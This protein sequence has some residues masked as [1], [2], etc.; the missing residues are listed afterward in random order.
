MLK[1]EIN[2]DKALI[3]TRV[4]HS[5]SNDEF[6]LKDYYYL[7][8]QRFDIAITNFL[9]MGRDVKMEIDVD[10]VKLKRIS[11]GVIPEKYAS[12]VCSVQVYEVA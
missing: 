12:N 1:N 7:G 8:K 4:R 3:I 9:L 10:G 5:L 6:L 11:T 2:E